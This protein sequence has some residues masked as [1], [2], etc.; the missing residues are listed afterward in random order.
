[1]REGYFA[2]HIRRHAASSIAPQARRAGR[3]AGSGAPVMRWRS[4]RRIRACIWSPI[5]ATRRRGDVAL[6]GARR[7]IRGVI[8]R[9]LSPM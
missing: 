8:V 1:M 6:G 5:C 7:A 3:R 4:R 9:P 2:A